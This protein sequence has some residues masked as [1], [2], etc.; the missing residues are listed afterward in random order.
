MEMTD[1]SVNERKRCVDA[2]LNVEGYKIRFKA[3]DIRS[4]RTGTHAK[5]Y[6][7]VDAYLKAWDNFNV[8]RSAERTRLANAAHRKYP[9]A[10]KQLYS[11]N[12][13]QHD[14][15]MFATFIWPKW[16]E[17]TTPSRVVGYTERVMPEFVLNPYIVRGGGTIIFGP[18]ERM[19]TMTALTM[20]ICVDAGLQFPFTTEQGPVLYINL[21]RPEGSMQRRLGDLNRALGL[22]PDRP[23]MMLN[24]RGKSLAMVEDGIEKAVAEEGVKVGFLDSISRAG[25]GDLIDNR[26]ANQTIDIM[27]G[28][29]DTWV[30]I[31]HSPRNDSTHL[32]GSMHFEAGA[33]ILIQLLTEYTEEN[34][35]GVGF[36]VV[37]SNDMKR[38]PI[39]SI[40]YQFDDYGVSHIWHPTQADFPELLALKAAAGGQTAE[41]KE[42]LLGNGA[43]HAEEIAKAINFSR[44]SVAKILSASKLFTVVDKVGH[45]VFYGVADQP[46]KGNDE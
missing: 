41:I 45:K 18:P 5:I 31:A 42:F 3:E 39:G 13:L 37:K 11:A 36:Q 4:E 30:G 10:L 43:A 7:G 40:G 28:L 22:S 26:V 1:L 14:L 21:E 6:L 16:V 23:I 27:N 29:F 34:T 17:T 46:F 32:F 25:Y 24:A 15:D 38:P 44:G 12:Q 8:E 33:D 20:A 35:I 2:T 19:K 9:E